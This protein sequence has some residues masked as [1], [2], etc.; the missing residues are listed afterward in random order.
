MK[1]DYFDL[2]VFDWYIESILS[3]TLRFS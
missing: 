1:H 3:L 2:K